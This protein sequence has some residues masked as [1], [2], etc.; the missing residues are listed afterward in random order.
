[1]RDTI[2]GMIA[3]A[4]EPKN[5]RAYHKDFDAKGYHHNNAGGMSDSVKKRYVYTQS[6][7]NSRDDHR[8]SIDADHGGSHEKPAKFKVKHAVS[9]QYWGSRWED[10]EPHKA[11]YEKEHRSAAGALRDAERL[12]KSVTPKK[13]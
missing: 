13:K 7:N 5:H 1:M 10:P 3:E 9:R 2:R 12:R 11:V 6:V 8:I 4:V